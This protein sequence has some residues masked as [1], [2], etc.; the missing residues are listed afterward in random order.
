M[1]LNL[2]DS[3]DLTL[4][5]VGEFIASVDDSA[6]RQLRVTAGGVA[7]ISDTVAG[8]NLEGLAFRL[9]TWAEGNGHVG[10]RAAKK[11]EWVKRVH[12][13][14]KRNWP[15]PTDTFIDQY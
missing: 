10:P 3:E 9:E 13:V 12:A 2:N 15:K 7:F 6:D 8:R 4:K 1:T 11:E 14:L 5:R